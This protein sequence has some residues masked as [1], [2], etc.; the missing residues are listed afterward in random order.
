MN[1][2]LLSGLSIILGLFLL[3]YKGLLF[4]I[5][6]LA[7]GF[8]KILH[9]LGFIRNPE[10]FRGSFAEGIAYVKDY[11]DADIQKAF[12]EASKLIRNFNL[13]DYVIIAIYY[14][15][16]KTVENE[17]QRSSIGIYRRSKTFP[18]K[19][20]EEFERYCTENGY[21]E[22][23]LPTATS[24]YSQWFYYTS[25]TLMIG[26]QKFYSSLKSQRYN[27]T[28]KRNMRINDPNLITTCVE[29]Y[30]YEEKISFYVPLLF[31]DN[32]MLYKNDK[33]E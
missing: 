3:L 11:E 28:F 8:Y 31:R 25:Y 16:I 14:D 5:I 4:A 1:P 32:F 19:M 2:F 9:A 27:E 15:K 13:K 12:I 23:E 29:L 26:I 24:I 30:E 33:K 17:K 21:N 7:F 6:P 10:F 20:P 22:F 18:E